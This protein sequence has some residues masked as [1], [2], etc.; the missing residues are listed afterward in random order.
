MI[1]TAP[2]TLPPWLQTRQPI[3]E[4]IVTG[5]LTVDIAAL[6]VSV[7]GGRLKLPANELR[8]LV[9]LA[10][11]L[12]RAVLYDELVRLIWW[13]SYDASDER[14]RAVHE[15]TV[16]V[17]LS[18]LRRRL[19]D[20]AAGLVVTIP[21]IG[22]RLERVPP[23]ESPPPWPR[24]ASSPTLAALGR[25]ARAHARCI[26]CGST[27]RRHWAHGLCEGCRPHD[28]PARWDVLRRRRKDTEG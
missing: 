22:V 3:D 15:H 10:T 16:R 11:R 26:A 14:M 20:A 27:A 12:G 8:L 9:V 7:D 19:G 6:V 2:S 1:A 24:R 25:W 5:R 13:S 21:H 28:R 18:R 23:G 4:L 17:N